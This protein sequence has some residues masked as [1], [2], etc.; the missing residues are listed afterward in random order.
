M[1]RISGWAE[2]RDLEKILGV[3]DEGYVDFEGRDKAAARV[4]LEAELGQR[5]G[6]VIHVLATR[7]DEIGAGE[8]SIRTDLAVSSGAAEFFRRLVRVSA[9]NYRFRIQLRKRGRDW[10][11]T[12]ASW[13]W[14]S[15]DDLFPESRSLLKKFLPLD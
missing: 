4:L 9:D 5:R 11:I 2:D 7:I 13:E 6:I 8:A 12:A 14:I 1:E 10:K 15:L 3:L